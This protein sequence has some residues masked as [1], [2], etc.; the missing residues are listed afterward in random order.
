M[1]T[2]LISISALVLAQVATPVFAAPVW[3]SGLTVEH[4]EGSAS[5]TVYFNEATPNPAGCSQGP[6]KTVSWEATNAAAKNFMAMM[7]TA[8]VSGRSVQVLVD[9]SSCLW[10]G[11]PS[12]VS[13]K[14]L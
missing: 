8:K 6:L 2:S 14:L 9:D 13:I 12:L 11:W 1:K 10:G 7:L 3:S 4:M 5:M